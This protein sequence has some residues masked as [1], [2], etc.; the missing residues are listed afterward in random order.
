MAKGVAL[1]GIVAS[2]CDRLSDAL[3]VG[4]FQ[5]FRDLEGELQG[6]CHRE[7]PALDPLGQRVAFDQ[8]QEA[9]ASR[10]PSMSLVV[11]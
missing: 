7:R 2:G 11:N 10:R 1:S 8:F 9:R 3:L 6:V 5:G 4:R